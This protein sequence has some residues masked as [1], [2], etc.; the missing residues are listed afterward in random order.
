M[1]IINYLT[2]FEHQE[3]SAGQIPLR[4]ASWGLDPGGP[5]GRVS[6]HSSAGPALLE[7]EPSWI[8]AEPVGSC[9]WIEPETLIKKIKD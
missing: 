8:L 6:S 1:W 5:Q 4:A 7:R 2:D 3:V 9:N